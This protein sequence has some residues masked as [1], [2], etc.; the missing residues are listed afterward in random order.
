MTFSR[1]RRGTPF[2]S[3]TENSLGWRSKHLSRGGPTRTSARASRRWQRPESRATWRLHRCSG[4]CL[5]SPIRSILPAGSLKTYRHIIFHQPAL[6]IVDVASCGC[7]RE[8]FPLEASGK[9]LQ[10]SSKHRRA[11]PTRPWSLPRRRS[12][13]CSARQGNFIVFRWSDQS[14]PLACLN[15]ENRRCRA[16]TLA[17]F[18]KGSE[19]PGAAVSLFRP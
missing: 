11:S 14:T 4:P 3:L 5:E 10:T 17:A 19:Q 8:S 2:T 18:F 12:G 9:V 6:V 13:K 1:K 7:P 16:A 15:L